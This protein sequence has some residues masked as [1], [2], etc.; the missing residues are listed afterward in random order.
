[1]LVIACQTYPIKYIG[2]NGLMDLSTKYKLIIAEI[3]INE[4]LKKLTTCQQIELNRY[5]SFK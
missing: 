5:K 4:A 3:G 1:M 2:C